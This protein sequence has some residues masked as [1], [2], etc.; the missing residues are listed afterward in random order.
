MKVNCN[1]QS[2]REIN[3]NAIKFRLL[4]LVFFGSI[5]LYNPLTIRFDALV[6]VMSHVQVLTFEIPKIFLSSAN[7]PPFYE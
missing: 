7:V 3:L 4:H 1:E 6:F 5:C 2:V